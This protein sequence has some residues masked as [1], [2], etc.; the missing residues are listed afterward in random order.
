MRKEEGRVFIFVFTDGF[1]FYKHRRLWPVRALWGFRS[2]DTPNWCTA[3]LWRWDQSTHFILCVFFSI[4]CDTLHCVVLFRYFV[5]SF[6]P[7]IYMWWSIKCRVGLVL[8]HSRSGLCGRRCTPCYLWL[9][10][11]RHMG[12]QQV[13]EWVSEWVLFLLSWDTYIVLADNG[14]LVSF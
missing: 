7:L 10:L 13:S 11:K 3:S 4:W 5:C 14:R 12:L 2:M 9:E 6:S 8:H 1:V